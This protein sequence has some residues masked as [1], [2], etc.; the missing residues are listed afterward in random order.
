MTQEER[1][2]YL[3]DKFRYNR[4]EAEKLEQSLHNQSLKMIKDVL[5]GK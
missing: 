3:M 1:I 5:G 2:Q 4:A